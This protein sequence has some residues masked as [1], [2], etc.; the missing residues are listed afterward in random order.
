VRPHDLPIGTLARIKNDPIFSGMIVT[1]VW[2]KNWKLVSLT[3]VKGYP[4]FRT[5]WGWQVEEGQPSFELEVLQPGEHVV[6]ENS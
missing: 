4:A 2:D 6:L 1:S 5:T 3:G